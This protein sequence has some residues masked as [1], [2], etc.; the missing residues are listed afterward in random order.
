MAT[1]Q[2]ELDSKR[3][4]LSLK[5]VVGELVEN[6]SVEEE[7]QTIFFQVSAEPFEVAFKIM[8]HPCQQLMTI[9]SKLSFTVDEQYRSA[10]SMAVNDL[11][12][13]RMYKGTFDFSVQKGI[14]VYRI[15][16]PYRKS[17]IS[18]ELLSDAI[19]D[20]FDTVTKYNQYLYDVSHGV[21]A[22]IPQ[23]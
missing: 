3:M 7:K 4:F 12:Y 17:L 14:T 10:Y 16:V 20:T 19:R 6:Y 2:E 5:T 9:Y 8:L 22:T 15:P 18:R 23:E 1:T 21:E 11:N 13:D